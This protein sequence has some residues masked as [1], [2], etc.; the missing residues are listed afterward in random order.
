MNKCPFKVGDKIYDI[1][2]NHTAVVTKITKR[3][4]KYKYEEPYYWHVLQPPFEGGECYCDLED[5]RPHWEFWTGNNKI[6]DI[7]VYES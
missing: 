5:Y 2:D 6:K 1:Y 3:G 7:V 4:F